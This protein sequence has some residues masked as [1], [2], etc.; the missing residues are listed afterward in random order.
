KKHVK[1]SQG[2]TCT[3]CASRNLMC[4]YITPKKRGPKVSSGSTNGFESEAANIERE[5]ALTLFIP[6]YLDYNEEPQSIQG[7]LANQINFDT[8]MPNNGMPVNI[9]DTYSLPS[10]FSSSFPSIASNL[11]YPFI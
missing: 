4:I 1:C 7:L 3:N 5:H 6:I 9:S 11:D 10:N 8:I 2:T